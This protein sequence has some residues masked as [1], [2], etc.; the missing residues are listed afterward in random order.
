MRVYTRTYSLACKCMQNLLNNK[1]CNVK[2]AKKRV[3]L[4]ADKIKIYGQLAIN[5]NLDENLDENLDM[6]SKWLRPQ[7]ST[8]PLNLFSSHTEHTKYTDFFSH[9][10]V[11]LLTIIAEHIFAR[12]PGLTQKN[13][14]YAGVAIRT[15][16]RAKRCMKC[17]ALVL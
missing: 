8:L 15:E 16:I 6:S 11:L 10:V 14:R 2:V 7:H 5:M 1:K 12:R 9:G 4:S 13:T 17:S 3:F